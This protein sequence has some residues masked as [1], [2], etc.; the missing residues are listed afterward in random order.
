[1]YNQPCHLPSSHIL[2][3]GTDITELHRPSTSQNQN[4]TRTERRERNKCL[5][6]SDRGRHECQKRVEI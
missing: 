4:V 3:A 5:K 1:M 6:T 2:P